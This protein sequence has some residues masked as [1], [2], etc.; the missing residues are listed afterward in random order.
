[1]HSVAGWLA[2]VHSD[3][4]AMMDDYFRNDAFV[5]G[6]LL[7]KEYHIIRLDDQA[8]FR[9][10]GIGELELDAQGRHLKMHGTIQD[11]TGRK[12]TKIELRIAAIAVESQEG[13]SVA[14]ADN[15]I[16]R[17]NHVFTNITGYAAEKKA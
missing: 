9:V 10:H 6:K 17:V 15:V 3:D 1:M 13:M 14:D 7:Y 4:R 11:I 2:L 5:L 16:I 8:E 12:K